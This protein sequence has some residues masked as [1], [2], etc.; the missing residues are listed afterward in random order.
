MLTLTYALP[1]FPVG[2]NRRTWRKPTTFPQNVDHLQQFRPY[3]S[4][5]LDLSILFK[6]ELSSNFPVIIQYNKQWFSKLLCEEDK[7]LSIS[8]K[9]GFAFPTKSV[10]ASS[11]ALINPPFCENTFLLK[12]DRSPYCIPK[13]STVLTNSSHVRQHILLPRITNNQ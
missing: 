4:A 2:G 1:T 8:I 7:F 10:G 9:T 13:N 6:I 12:R 11:V 3:K 5:I